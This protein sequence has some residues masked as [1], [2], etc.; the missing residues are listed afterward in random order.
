MVRL[1]FTIICQQAGLFIIIYLPAYGNWRLPFTWWFKV[2]VRA[3]RV[4]TCDT[5]VLGDA[6]E[7]YR[8]FIFMLFSLT[9]LSF[10]KTCVS[11]VL[12]LTSLLLI[13]CP[14]FNQL[15]ARELT[16]QV[17]YYARSASSFLCLKCNFPRPGS[18]LTCSFPWSLPLLR[19]WR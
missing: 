19:V 16:E 9:E 15:W 18:Y 13:A 5:V 14:C 1:K 7:M 8:L 6:F 12:P 10:Y 4:F 17:T 3:S 2:I 11:L